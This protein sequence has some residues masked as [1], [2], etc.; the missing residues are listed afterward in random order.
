VRQNVR[1]TRDK[2]RDTRRIVQIQAENARYDGSQPAVTP[3]ASPRATPSCCAR[4]AA[5]PV[6]H[7]GAALSDGTLDLHGADHALGR[8]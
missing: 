6:G 2:T 1:Q 3:V 4:S 5:L 8:E 7:R